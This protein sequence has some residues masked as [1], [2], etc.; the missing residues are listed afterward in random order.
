[1][2]FRDYYETRIE[3]A[4][5]GLERAQRRRSLYPHGT[6]RGLDIALVL[7]TLPI[8]LPLILIMMCLVSLDGRSPIYLQKRLGRNGRVFRMVK[9]R[10]MVPRADALLEDYLRENP[11]ARHE[12][13][14]S[15]KLKCD[16]RITATGSFLRK[17]SLDELPQLWNVLIGD[18]SLVGPRPMMVDQESLYPGTAYFELRPGITGPWQVSERNESSFADRAGFDRRYLA[19]MSLAQDL[20]ILMR[21]VAVVIRGTGY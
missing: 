9:I 10:T 2:A 21:T 14:E 16:P 7:V 19:S 3:K 20:T 18:M 1:M 11:A 17:S 5:S 13:N 8:S 6:K 12:W 4:Q 15:Q